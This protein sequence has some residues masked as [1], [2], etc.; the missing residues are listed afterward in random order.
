MVHRETEKPD[1]GP[2]TFGRRPATVT[3]SAK[4]ARE[5]RIMVLV[6][7]SQHE[8]DGAVRVGCRR[9]NKIV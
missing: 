2:E 1:F 3:P 5:K 9:L 6:P 4:D 8:R 7:V